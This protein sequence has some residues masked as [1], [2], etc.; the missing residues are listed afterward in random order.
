[1]IKTDLF[2]GRNKNFRKI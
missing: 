2:V 1:V